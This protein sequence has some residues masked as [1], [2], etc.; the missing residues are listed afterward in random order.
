MGFPISENLSESCLFAKKLMPSHKQI[1]VLILEAQASTKS[2]ETHVQRVWLVSTQI[3][4]INS[5]VGLALVFSHIQ[6]EQLAKPHKSLAEHPHIRDSKAQQA[7]PIH[8][9]PSK[10]YSL[11]SENIESRQCSGHHHGTNK[12]TMRYP[13]C[14]APSHFPYP[15]VTKSA[16]VSPQ[17]RAGGWGGP[18]IPVTSGNRQTQTVWLIAIIIVVKNSQQE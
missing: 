3:V 2:M 16:T 8:H 10:N 7:P 18:T 4:V 12:S 13:K 5:G 17:P 14:S 9:V 11:T 6:S 15:I 1:L